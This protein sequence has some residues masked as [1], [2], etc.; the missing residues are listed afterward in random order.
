MGLVPSAQRALAEMENDLS[1]SDP[2]LVAMFAGFAGD[3]A[4]DP[5]SARRPGPSARPPGPDLPSWYGP[6][7]RGQHA[8]CTRVA[9]IV[10][11]FTMLIACVAMAILTG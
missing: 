1:Q 8:R 7:T 4:R 6:P 10:A 2:A 5:A 11:L 3:C 9:V